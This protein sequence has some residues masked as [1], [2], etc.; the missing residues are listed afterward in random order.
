[1]SAG[2]QTTVQNIHH[3]DLTRL[4]T[5]RSSCLPDENNVAALQEEVKQM[6]L[7][8]LEMLRSFREMQDTVSELN[9]RWQVSH[10]HTLQIGLIFTLMPRA[11]A[12]VTPPCALRSSTCRAAA[13][14]AAAA[15][16]GRNRRR[17]TP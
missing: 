17:R 3:D 8:E 15:V 12:A 6:K 16:T 5:Q 9:Q 1:M 7:R 14:R 10:T 13:A 2:A 4:P 11:T